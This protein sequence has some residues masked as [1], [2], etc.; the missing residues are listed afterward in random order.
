MSDNLRKRSGPTTAME[1]ARIAGV[2]QSAVSRAFTSGASVSPAARERIMAAARQLG[3]RPNAIARSL[4]KGRSRLIGIIVAYM[5]NQFYPEVLEAI[6]HR[7]QALDYHVILFSADATRSVDP[8]FQS[9]MN[10]RLDGIV[11]A[12]AMLSSELAS[13]CH[14]HNVPVV[15]FNRKTD[16]AELSSVTGDNQK[17]AAQIAAFLACG[18]HKRFGFIA[19]IEAASTSRDRERGYTA[20]LRR[21]DFGEPVR[22][23]GHYSFSGASAAA[24]DLLSRKARPDAIFCAND[25]TAIAAIEVARHEFGLDVGRDVSIVGFD[26]VGAARWPSYG[27]TTF[28]QP[29]LPMVDET[30]AILMEMIEQ[31]PGTP[32]H[33][34]IPGD[35]V[36]RSSARVPT[37]GVIESF[38]GRIWRPVAKVARKP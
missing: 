34:V 33:S 9:I 2:S 30:V 31:Q 26:D 5:E 1:V 13:E 15:L 22:A 25:H 24:R 32:R 10:Y 4:I 6:S 38:S 3:Y 27:L 18:G 12:S 14:A 19:G 28:S 21:N 17:G 23:V 16:A 29:V 8:A 35:L 20:W 7:L 11:L 37:Q 36:V